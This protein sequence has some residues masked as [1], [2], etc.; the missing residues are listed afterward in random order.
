MLL[1]VM[2]DSHDNIWNLEKA[3]AEA[4]DRGCSVIIHCGDFVAP[5]SLKQMADSGLP[6]YAVFG[7]NDGDRFLLTRTAAAATTP[8]HLFDPVG[9]FADGAFN[10]AF[11]HHPEVGLG[12]AS[13]GDYD[14]V[15]H[16]HTHLHYSQRINDTLLLNPGEIMGK[17]GNP[18]FCV[19]DTGTGSFERVEIRTA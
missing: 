11:T 19:V 2:S 3:L 13:T 5:F 4:G 8:V 18:G 17:E 1:A 12:L 16:G 9:L 14:A 7:N 10:V 15:F 6:V